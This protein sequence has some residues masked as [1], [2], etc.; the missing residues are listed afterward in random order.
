LGWC[1]PGLESAAAT[2]EHCPNKAILWVAPFGVAVNTRVRTPASRSLWAHEQLRVRTPSL[3]RLCSPAS[4]RRPLLAGCK[5]LQTHGPR[6]LPCWFAG[7]FFES[8][9]SGAVLKRQLRISLSC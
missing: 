1:L 2:N 7:Q 6:L 9:E 5:P 8:V 4:Q 3:L